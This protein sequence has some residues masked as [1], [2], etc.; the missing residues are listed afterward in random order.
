MHQQWKPNSDFLNYKGL[1]GLNGNVL[2]FDLELVTM[3]AIELAL[4]R[5]SPR[6]EIKWSPQLIDYCNTS[7]LGV[8]NYLPFSDANY[9]HAPDMFVPFMGINLRCVS[10][11]P[12]IFTFSNRN[13]VY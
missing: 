3:S 1:S 7:R 4:V 9:P 13:S 5:P 11:P 6:N 2:S 12:S 8:D 10:P